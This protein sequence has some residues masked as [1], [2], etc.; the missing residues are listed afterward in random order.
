MKSC[1]RV[2]D[3][4]CVKRGLCPPTCRLLGRAYKAA[5]QQTET[6]RVFRRGSGITVPAK[7][8]D[9]TLGDFDNDGDLDAI[10]NCVN[11]VPQLLRCDSTL[12]RSW[13]KIRV[14]GTRSNRIGIGACL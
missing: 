1:A 9:F 13:V 4:D 12:N 14:V 7:A 11:A 10:V 5:G 3:P 8:C 2:A 6:D